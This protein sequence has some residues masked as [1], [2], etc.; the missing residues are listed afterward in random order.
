MS[1]KVDEVISYLDEILPD[2][3]CELIAN[4]DYE[5]LICVM[6]SAQTTD[7]SVNKVTPKLFERFR[8]LEELNNA[9]IDEIKSYIHSLGLSYNKAKNVKGIASMLLKEYN[10]ILPKGKNELTKLPGVGIKTANVVRA[11]IFHEQEFAVDTHVA[12]IAKRLGFAK[13]EDTVEEIERKLRK[14]FPSDRYTKSHHQL[15]WFGR[16]YCSSKNPKCEECKLQSYCKY[17]KKHSK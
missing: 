12:R 17:Y 6:L 4:K 16:R 9:S 13:E 2:A 7:V 10:G 3:K 11:E 5:F 8:T 15:I 14:Q 1:K